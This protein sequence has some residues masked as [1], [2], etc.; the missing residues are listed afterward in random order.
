MPPKENQPLDFEKT[1]PCPSCRQG[2]LI[3][4]TL[5]EAWGCDY[6][7]QIFE[8]RE[9]LDTIG[10][11]AT[12]YHRQRIWRWNGTQWTVGRSAID[13]PNT[14]NSIVIVLFCGGLLWAGLTQIALPAFL[15]VAIVALGLL[16]VVRFWVLRQR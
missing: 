15:L 14:F 12:P 9:D 2:T 10:K 7:E 6:C 4:I 3:P 1:Y 5:T 16:L 8:R 11:V 13:K